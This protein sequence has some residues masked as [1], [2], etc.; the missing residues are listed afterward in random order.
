MLDD[1]NFL[2]PSARQSGAGPHRI[3]QG[4]IRPPTPAINRLVPVESS[5]FSWAP[6]DTDTRGEHLRIRR[7]TPLLSRGDYS[8]SKLLIS[9]FTFSTTSPR[10]KE[11]KLTPRACTY[12][13]LVALPIKVR[14]SPSS[15][16]LTLAAA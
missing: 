1:R 7:N 6:F 4:T 15:N 11:L 8:M 16:I 9:N 13:Q 3:D 2:A 12:V 14:K 5:S 10:R